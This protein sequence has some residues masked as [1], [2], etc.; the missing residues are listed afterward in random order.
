[1]NKKIQKRRVI[2]FFVLKRKIARKTLIKAL[3]LL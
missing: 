2:A 3:I 1:M